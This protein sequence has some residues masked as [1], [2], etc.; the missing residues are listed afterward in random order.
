MFT[1]KF[2]CYFAGKSNGKG[3]YIYEKGGKP[4]PDPSVQLVIDEYRRR[5]KTM[6][7]GKV[8]L[9]PLPV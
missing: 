6:P 9:L 1:V 5:A 2:P 7:G 4:K 3:Y 8:S